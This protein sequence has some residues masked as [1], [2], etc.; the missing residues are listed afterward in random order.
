MRFRRKYGL[1][2]DFI[3]YV[4]RVNRSK[5]CHD[6]FDLFATYKARRPGRLKLVLVG[7]VEMPVPARLDVRALGF[8]DEQDKQDAL[9]A[10]T[11]TVSASRYE[12][13]S[14]ALVESW[15]AGSPA[16]FSAA[17]GPVRELIEASGAGLHFDDAASFGAALDV[18][19]ADPDLRTR[20]AA[21]GRSY[22][23]AHHTWDAVHT[24]WLRAIDQALARTPR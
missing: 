12:S 2:D 7:N 11:L 17:A 9:A 21:A 14:M 18:L 23:S 24:G 22:A 16:L 19:L 20:M 1:A 6:L 3:L 4:G 13:F 8:V 10:A 5:G 15:M